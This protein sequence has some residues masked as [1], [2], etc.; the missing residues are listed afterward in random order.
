MMK[1][2]KRSKKIF[3]LLRD[4]SHGITG[5]KIAEQLGVSSRTIRSDIK[6]LQEAI[7]DV[8]IISASN[9]GYRLSSLENID[10]VYRKVFCEYNEGFETSQQRISYIL[11]RLLGNTFSDKAVTQADLAD[12]MFVSLS[13]MKVYF[14]Q[15]KKV[16]DRYNLKIIQYKACGIQVTGDEKDIRYC[17]SE[18]INETKLNKFWKNIFYDIN[19]VDL[20]TI[21][22]IILNKK[23]LQLTDAAKSNLCIHTAI[24]IKRSK[25]NKQVSYPA[26]MAQK[27]EETFEY[28]VAKEIVSAIYSEMGIDVSY[29]EAYYIT[30]CLLASKKVLD[31]GKESADKIHVKEMVNKILKEVKRTLSIDFTSDKYLIDGLTLHLNVTLSRIQFNMNIRNELL[32]T[33]K[34]DYPLAF[35]MGIIAGKVVEENDQIKVNENEIGYI[36]LHFGAAI[37]RNGINNKAKVKNVIIV[38]SAGLGMAVL[39]KA[40]IEE[41]FKGQ[42]NIKKI[43]PGYSVDKS[44]LDDVDFVLSTVPLDNIN[45]DKVIEIHHMLGKSDI[46]KIEQRILNKKVIEKDDI[47]DFFSEENFYVDKDFKEKNECLDFLTEEAIKKQLMTEQTKKSVFERESLSSTSIGELIAIPHPIYNDADTSF[48]SIC[49]LKQPIIWND[50]LVQAIFLLNIEKEKSQLWEE[51]FLKLYEYIKNNNGIKILL[52]TKSFDIFLHQFIENF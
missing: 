6:I 29:G 46:K 2:N 40:K 15:V 17:I 45:S 13:T 35:Q 8:K 19:V 31:I 4:H 48:I 43:I 14:N 24:A 18:Y 38:C 20:D 11:G 36:A 37:S 33:I 52:Q 34:N 28:N 32:K 26:S 3:E 16:L 47:V 1:L 25:I 39:L 21:I 49:T 22:K 50:F 10:N 12:E 42:I 9:W 5:K 51:I 27:I 44:I 23:N 30:Q 41:H 7:H